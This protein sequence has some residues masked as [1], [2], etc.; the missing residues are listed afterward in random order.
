MSK[1]RQQFLN[2]ANPVQPPFSVL[3]NLHTH[4]IHYHPKSDPNPNQ[5]HPVKVN[6]V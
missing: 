1:H 6:E 3:I 2:C 5:K 4:R